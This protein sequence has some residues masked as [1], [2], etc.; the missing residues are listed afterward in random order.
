[1]PPMVFR[2]RGQIHLIALVALALRVLSKTSLSKNMLPANLKY[3]GNV[4]FF[5]YVHFSERPS[6]SETS[7]TVKYG[8][9]I[10]SPIDSRTT[11]ILFY[12]IAH[13]PHKQLLKFYHEEFNNNK[14]KYQCHSIPG[15]SV[16][17]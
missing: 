1:M 14:E 3:P 17:V 10:V 5:W 6:I 15:N 9:S 4:S 7:L 8:D 16:K 11:L 13:R 2:Q 12:N